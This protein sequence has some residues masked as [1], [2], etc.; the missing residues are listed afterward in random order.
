MWCIWDDTTPSCMVLGADMSFSPG[1]SQ[2]RETA[3]FRLPRSS[4]C[5]LPTIEW[6]IATKPYPNSWW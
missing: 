3:H 2:T 4:L 6:A 1:I 5:W